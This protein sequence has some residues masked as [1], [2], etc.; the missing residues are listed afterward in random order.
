MLLLENVKNLIKLD[1]GDCIKR[2]VSELNAC[3]YDVTWQV[4][5]TDKVAGLAQ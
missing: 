3:G 5:S 1:D 2:V 4:L